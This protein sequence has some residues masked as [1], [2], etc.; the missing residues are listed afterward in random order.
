LTLLLR[1]KSE[2]AIVCSFALFADAV[3]YPYMPEG[4]NP[5]IFER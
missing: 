2:S 3:I 4:V 1:Q 5:K